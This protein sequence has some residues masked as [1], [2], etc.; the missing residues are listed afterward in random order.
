[1]PSL[2]TQEF[3]LSLKRFI[4]RKGRP[5]KIYSDNGSTYVSAVW[6]SRKA[7]SDEKFNQFLAQNKIVWQFN[8][9]RAPWWGA[10]F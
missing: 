8:I 3:I 9:S 6:W 1:M 10:Q 2:E 5:D 4:A 7:L